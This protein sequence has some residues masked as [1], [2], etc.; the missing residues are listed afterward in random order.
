MKTLI[1]ALGHAPLPRITR[2]PGLMGGRPTIRGLRVTVAMV[3][4]QLAAGQSI[5]ELLANFPYLERED[6]VQAMQYG[7]WLAGD[8]QES[9]LTV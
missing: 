1:G 4:N 3:L 6:I 9:L 5:D 2:I 8:E 7:A